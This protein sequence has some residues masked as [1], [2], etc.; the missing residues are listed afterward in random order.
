MCPLELTFDL[1]SWHS[2]LHGK[3]GTNSLGGVAAGA[4]TATAESDGQQ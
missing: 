1:C 2:S 4:G 3:A